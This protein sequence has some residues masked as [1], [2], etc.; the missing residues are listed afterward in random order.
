MQTIDDYRNQMGQD[1]LD[2]DE[3]IELENKYIET[4][5]K[6]GVTVDEIKR[7]VVARARQNQ[8]NLNLAKVMQALE[9]GRARPFDG[10]RLGGRKN[11]CDCGSGKL[12]GKCCHP[13]AKQ[14]LPA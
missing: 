3:K 12:Y 13:H 7:M 4:A 2:A 5:E 14:K 9:E 1:P 6:F 8:S 11:P 10:K